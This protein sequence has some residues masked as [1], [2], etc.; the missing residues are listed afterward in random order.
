[1]KLLHSV[2]CSLNG[3]NYN[4]F[5]MVAS[6]SDSLWCSTCSKTILEHVLHQRDSPIDYLLKYVP[7][8]DQPHTY[9]GDRD[10]Q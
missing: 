1:M 5:L 10:D 2:V 8:I 6:E 3:Y 9:R 4:S 7:K